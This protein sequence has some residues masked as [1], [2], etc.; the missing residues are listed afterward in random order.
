MQKAGRTRIFASI[1]LLHRRSLYPQ[2][3]EVKIIILQSKYYYWER[4]LRQAYYFELERLEAY[5][6]PMCARVRYFILLLLL[7]SLGRTS[8]ALQMAGFDTWSGMS[9]ITWVYR[10]W[11]RAQPSDAT[12]VN[13]GKS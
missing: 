7:R 11:K 6:E 1:V 9:S 13:G 8:V 12:H 10:K 3:G 4:S 2:L 5:G